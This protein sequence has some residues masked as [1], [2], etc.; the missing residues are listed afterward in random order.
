MKLEEKTKAAILQRIVD[1]EKNIDV[2]YSVGALV[3][4]TD[5][6]PEALGATIDAMTGYNSAASDKS[7]CWYLNAGDYPH[8]HWQKNSQSF[9][10]LNHIKGA[11]MKAKTY[12]SVQGTADQFQLQ[13]KARIIAGTN[14]GFFSVT[15]M[16]K[17]GNIKNQNARL[18]VKKNI[19]GTG[20]RPDIPGTVLVYKPKKGWRLLYLGNINAIRANGSDVLFDFQPVKYRTWN[21][22]F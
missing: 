10:I 12:K 21:K 8:K 16:D 20:K 6:V 3:N 22:R 4:I 19:K 15:Y 18:G 13:E 11:I 14:G 9:G 5:H 2:C 1:I 17:Q 7:S